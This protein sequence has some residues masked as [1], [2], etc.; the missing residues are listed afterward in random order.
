MFAKIYEMWKFASARLD[1]E[2]REKL[3]KEV[4]AEIEKQKITAPISTRAVG[5]V[6]GATI[7]RQVGKLINKGLYRT[8]VFS[9]VKDPRLLAGIIATILMGS[10]AAAGERQVS[11][12]VEKAHEA[13]K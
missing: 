4:L 3:A 12:A 7:G 5:V 9:Q 10:G 8:G 11:R 13:Q 1:S 6:G 2:G